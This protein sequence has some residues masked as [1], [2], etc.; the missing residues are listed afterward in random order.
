MLRFTDDAQHERVD[1]N[2]QRSISAP[3]GASVC[4]D[5]GCCQAISVQSYIGSPYS[6]GGNSV[7]PPAHCAVIFI[8]CF[9]L[10]L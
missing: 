3:R 10:N 1:S 2:G 7:S 4:D 6:K 5:G 9:T 8:L